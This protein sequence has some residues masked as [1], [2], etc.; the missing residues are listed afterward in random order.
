MAVVS[1]GTYAH[2]AGFAVSGGWSTCTRSVH[3]AEADGSRLEF[4]S[5]FAKGRSHRLFVEARVEG[6]VRTAPITA[7]V[8]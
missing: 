7:T 2:L 6:L 1:V 4:H 3:R 8:R 5:T